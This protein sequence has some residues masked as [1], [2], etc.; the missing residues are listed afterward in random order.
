VSDAQSFVTALENFEFL[1]GMVIS[2]DIF[3]IN[4]VIK[5]LQS[6]IVFTDVTLKQIEGVVSFFQQHRNKG[7]SA[8]TEPVKSIAWAM[9]IEPK[10]LRKCKGKRKKHFYK[11]DETKVHLL[12]VEF[13]RVNYFL[14]IVDTAIASLTS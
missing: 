3:P 5:K 9:D 6:K 7:F 14:V 10:F 1:V 8:I 11:Q 4:M 13:F 2:N 12:A